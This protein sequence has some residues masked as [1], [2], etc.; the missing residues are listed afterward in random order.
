MAMNRKTSHGSL[1]SPPFLG[2]LS[3]HGDED[4]GA[5][6]GGSDG[7]TVDALSGPGILKVGG[8]RGDPSRWFRL[9]TIHLNCTCDGRIEREGSWEAEGSHH[10]SINDPI[11]RE[12]QIDS[13]TRIAAQS[14]S[15]A[16]EG[17]VVHQ[18]LGTPLDLHMDSDTGKKTSS[19]V[20]LI[21]AE[22]NQRSSSASSYR[23]F[24][25]V[26]GRPRHSG[27]K[28]LRRHSDENQLL[29]TPH[30]HPGSQQDDQVCRA[31][32]R[33]EESTS[34]S[35]G[36]SG[37]RRGRGSARFGGRTNASSSS[38]YFESRTNASKSGPPES[39]DPGPSSLREASGENLD[40]LSAI[41]FNSMVEVEEEEEEEQEADGSDELDGDGS[42]TSS[43]A[44]SIKKGRKKVEKEEEEMDA[45]VDGE[46]PAEPDSKILIDGHDVFY[47]SLLN[48]KEPLEIPL[49][50]AVKRF[51][52]SKRAKAHFP[53]PTLSAYHVD[54]VVSNPN[55]SLSV[56]LEALLPPA[57]TVDDIQ[58]LRE[59]TL[60]VASYPTSVDHGKLARDDAKA[61]QT[62]AVSKFH[63]HGP[64]LRRPRSTLGGRSVH[65]VQ[66]GKRDDVWGD[67]A[68]EGTE[69]EGER[70]D[71]G[72]LLMK[73][74]SIFRDLWHVEG[75]YR[76]TVRSVKGTT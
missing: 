59:W 12:T 5:G 69:A 33:T 27:P 70:R 25:E 60:L 51:D 76:A 28:L 38:S 10:P 43:S 55:A 6:D 36:G 22:S 62:A 8:G 47:R 16:G 46:R 56:V 21:P 4:G 3:G 75:A 26:R 67:S 61:A 20:P 35:G 32:G 44:A 2:V 48:L 23:S 68:R 13:R 50:T 65:L 58:Q 52:T 7:R 37:G 57:A 63:R 54:A 40:D 71:G 19:S 74:G 34:H 66:G 73:Y 31:S 39:K 49:N 18:E 30:Q 64:P 14:L 1:D 72:V 9:R 29:L 53:S 11:L 45:S 41:L 24:L 17:L 42:S 15:S